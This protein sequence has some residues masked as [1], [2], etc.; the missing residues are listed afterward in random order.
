MFGLFQADSKFPDF[1]VLVQA[2]VGVHIG[3]RSQRYLRSSEVLCSSSF[4]FW[5]IGATS[6]IMFNLKTFLFFSI[7]SLIYQYLATN[8]EGFS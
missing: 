6:S 5:M 4:I 8:A 3:H 1:G 7:Q 2:L